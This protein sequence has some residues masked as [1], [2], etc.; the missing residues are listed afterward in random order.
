MLYAA[1]KCSPAD[2]RNMDDRWGY[3]FLPAQ[4]ANCECNIGWIQIRENAIYI[5][6]M[7]TD[8]RICNFF[9]WIQIR[10]Y[11]MNLLNADMIV[12]WNIEIYLL[13]TDT[14][15]FNKYAE[16]RYK[17]TFTRTCNL[18]ANRDTGLCNI[19]V[20]YRYQSMQFIC[21]IQIRHT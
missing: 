8:T 10:E 1:C 16:C 11:A 14:R 7:N 2:K 21:W 15:N 13:D 18:S 9:C 19:S 5:Y 3:R 20:G 4:S 17:S 12:I 6:V